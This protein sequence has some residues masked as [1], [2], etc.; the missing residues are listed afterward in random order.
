M[1]TSPKNRDE[2]DEAEAVADMKEHWHAQCSDGDGGSDATL[3]YAHH[4]DTSTAKGRAAILD[5]LL[6]EAGESSLHWDALARISRNLLRQ[7]Q[8]IPARLADWTAEVLDRALKRKHVGRPGKGPR[9]RTFVRDGAIWLEMYD[10][11]DLWTPVCFADTCSGE[12]HTALSE[13]VAEAILGDRSQYGT[14]EKV[15]STTRGLLPCDKL[16]LKALVKRKKLALVKRKKLAQETTR[17][18]SM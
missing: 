16:G 18:K 3:R 6:R 12:R 8:Y 1:R 15:W 10:R 2:R 4:Y 13:L 7:R 9:R 5:L 11:C 14:V 17:K